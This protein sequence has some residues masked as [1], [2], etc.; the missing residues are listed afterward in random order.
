MLGRMKVSDLPTAKLLRLLRASE[1]ASDPDE[2]ALSVLR[3]ELNRRLDL[4][5]DQDAGS[6]RREELAR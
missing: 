5:K 2:Y 1:R 4:A 3:R 6:T